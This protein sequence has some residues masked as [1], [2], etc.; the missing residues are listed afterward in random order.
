MGGLGFLE[1]QL[2][3][4]LGRLFQERTD[5]FQRFSSSRS[6]VLLCTVSVDAA[7]GPTP[8]AL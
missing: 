2:V 1:R 5:V 8:A 6:G 7:S 3:Q 4:M